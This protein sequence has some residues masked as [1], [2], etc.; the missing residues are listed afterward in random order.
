MPSLASYWYTFLLSLRKP[1]EQKLTWHVCS[2][3]RLAYFGSLSESGGIG[4][5]L[6]FFLAATHM[7]LDDLC[8]RIL[9]KC[10]DT[11]D[12]FKRSDGHNRAMTCMAR[13]C[14]MV[15]NSGSE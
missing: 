10:R 8:R 4:G 6:A 13:A 3:S 7:P 9:R 15:A 1:F 2:K 5:S 11:R 12:M 14:S